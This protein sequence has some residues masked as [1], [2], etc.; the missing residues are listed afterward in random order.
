MNSNSNVNT[1]NVNSS[2]PDFFKNPIYIYLL[3]ALI[4]TLIGIL[5]NIINNGFNMVTLCSYISSQLSSIL[6]CSLI[7]VSSF[8]INGI[9]GWISVLIFSICLLCT[10]CTITIGY[11]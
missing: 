8:A 2:L 7:I 9:M 11:K 4:A 1:T 6:V 3:I 5:I 10:S